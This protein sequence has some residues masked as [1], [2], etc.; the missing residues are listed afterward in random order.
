MIYSFTLSQVAIA[1]GLVELF[2]TTLSLWQFD[3][4]RSF[5]KGFH[6][7][8]VLGYFLLSAVTAWVVWLLSTMDLMD[9]TDWRLRFIMI[10]LILAILVARYLPDYLSVRAG[11]VLLA[12]TAN[13]LLDAAFLRDEPSKFVIT[14]IA[15]ILILKSIFWIS[16]PYLVR[17][18]V[19]WLYA[20]SGRAKRTYILGGTLALILIYLGCFVY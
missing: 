1:L 20:N 15:Y 13:V 18:K 10:V 11:G 12:L 9:Y 19:E 7:N 17:N 14:A 8:R 16:M 2:F 3:A 4:M 6:R 5:W